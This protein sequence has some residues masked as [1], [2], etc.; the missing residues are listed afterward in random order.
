MTN[1]DVDV[2]VDVDVFERDPLKLVAFHKFIMCTCLPKRTER[3]GRANIQ[4]FEHTLM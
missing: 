3:L 4:H 1:V 2:D